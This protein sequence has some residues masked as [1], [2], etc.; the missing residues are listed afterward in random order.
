MIPL[1][2]TMRNDHLDV[3]F[4]Y[5]T[6]DHPQCLHVWKIVGN[7]G[8]ANAYSRDCTGEGIPRRNRKSP[9]LRCAACHVAW[10]KRGDKLKKRIKERASLYLAVQRAMLVPLLTDADIKVCLDL[11]RAGNGV[12]NER[13]V[14]L[15]NKAQSLVSFYKEAKV[16]AWHHCFTQPHF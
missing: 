14:V 12:L 9:G 10:E 1:N 13:G 2:N 4:K 7:S 3:I 5:A 8:Q 16:R 11:T 6:H 15:K